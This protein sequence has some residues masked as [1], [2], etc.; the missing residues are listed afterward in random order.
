MSLKFF[1]VLV[2]CVKCI[3]CAKLCALK[4]AAFCEGAACNQ[5]QYDF[6]LTGKL[7]SGALVSLR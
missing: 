2:A 6:K 3:A 1:I 4:E 7:A 5:I